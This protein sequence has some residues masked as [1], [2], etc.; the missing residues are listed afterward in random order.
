MKGLFKGQKGISL[1]ETVVALAILATAGV[2]FLMS[3][4]T[5]SND[6]SIYNERSMALTLA[7]SACEEIKAMSFASSYS[8]TGILTPPQGYTISLTVTPDAQYPA[9]KQQ[10]KVTVTRGVEKAAELTMTK[11]DWQ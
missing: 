11:T 4:Y 10:V 2:G 3:L 1:I 7:Q 6:R 5:M 8:L 9:T